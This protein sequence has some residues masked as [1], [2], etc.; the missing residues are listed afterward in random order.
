MSSGLWFS[1]GSWDN[2][3]QYMPSAR[4]E[5]PA[6]M[7]RLLGGGGSRVLPGRV[8]SFLAPWA[9]FKELSV[10][11][12]VSLLRHSRLSGRP[13][14]TTNTDVHIGHWDSISNHLTY[15]KS[16]KFHTRWVE[17]ITQKKSHLST[18]NKFG[19]CLHGVRVWS[20]GT[21]QVQLKRPSTGLSLAQFYNLW[22]A[23]G[24]EEMGSY[25]VFG[26][27]KIKDHLGNVRICL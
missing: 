19:L 27:K 18:G 22:Q 10:D 1:H 15:L 20:L 8:F 16:W 24:W 9:H 13:F 12:M 17:I 23:Q 2:H 3:E 4:S 26:N 6:A 11:V 21:R 7:D 25:W 5:P 14:K